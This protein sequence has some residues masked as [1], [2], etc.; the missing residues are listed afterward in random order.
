MTRSSLPGAR[1]YDTLPPAA[2][3]SLVV[4]VIGAQVALAWGLLQM[5]SV[6]SAV[7]EMAPIVVE[8]LPAAAPPPPTP[9]PPVPR[10]AR[11]IPKPVP[12]IAAAPSPSPAPAPAFVAPPPEPAPLPPVIES[13]PAPASPPTPAPRAIDIDAVR[14]L[15]QPVL[16]YPP[17]S[18]R[19]GEQGQVNVRVLVDAKGLPAQLSVVRSSGFTRLDEAALATVRATRFK[20]YTENGMPLEFWVVMPLVFDLE[21]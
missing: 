13:P 12:V 4:G 9:P 18:R 20:P 7:A 8:M 3:R 11:L 2:R 15:V 14:Y 21:N 5:D 17:L 16:K 10:P 1:R 6:R 19:A